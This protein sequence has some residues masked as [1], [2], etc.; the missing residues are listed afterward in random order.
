MSVSAST[1]ARWDNSIGRGAEWRVATY[2][3][4]LP[5]VKL[6]PAL[7]HPELFLLC[8]RVH[9]LVAQVITCLGE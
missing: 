7:L 3:V 1:A 5:D 9:L 4:F 8:H 2:E 6:A